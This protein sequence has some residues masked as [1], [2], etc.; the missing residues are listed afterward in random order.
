HRTIGEH[1]VVADGRVVADVAADQQHVVVADARL[2]AAE[3]GA[4]VDRRMLADAVVFADAQATRP[5]AG[6]ELLVLRMAADHRE[7]EQFAVFADPGVA[8]DDD[9]RVQARACAQA[10]LGPDR[11][12]RPDLDIVRQDGAVGDNRSRVNAH[13]GGRRGAAVGATPAG[14]VY[15]SRS[16]DATLRPATGRTGC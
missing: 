12:V 15:P 10:D 1:H 5:I 6:L 7:R 16:P 11:A 2:A 13:R 9:V 14:N 3:R 4:A 8:V